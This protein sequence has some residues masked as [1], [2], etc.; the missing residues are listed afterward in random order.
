MLVNVTPLGMAGPEADQQAFDDA[1]LRR[2]AWVFDVVAWPA[3]TP[4]IH[5]ARRLHKPMI[6]GDE[7]QVLQAVEQFVLYT[8]LRPSA[9]QVEAVAAHARSLM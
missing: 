8:G 2:A 9:A 3:E 6:R 4:L 7:V 1:L 5:A